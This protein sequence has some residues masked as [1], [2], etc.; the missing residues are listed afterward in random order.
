MSTG[1]DIAAD[2][3]LDNCIHRGSRKSPVSQCHPHGHT[4][5]AGASAAP[6][7]RFAQPIQPV[8]LALGQ[9]RKTRIVASTSNQ[10]GPT[11]GDRIRS[12]SPGSAVTR[13]PRSQA[14]Q[15]GAVGTMTGRHCTGLLQNLDL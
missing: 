7:P 9:C 13:C 1:S 6:V 8:A 12:V 5:Q 2:H 10:P 3:R 15:L 4:H 14:S 11:G